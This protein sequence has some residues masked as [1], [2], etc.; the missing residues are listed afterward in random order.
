MS[1]TA[2]N[3]VNYPYN[4]APSATTWSGYWHSSNL[5][6]VVQVVNKFKGAAGKLV[7]AGTCRVREPPSGVEVDFAR[8]PTTVSRAPFERAKR[9]FDEIGFPEDR[10]G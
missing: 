10:D 4:D 5:G 7:A 6:A 3:I 9:R 2:D 8:P 1:Y